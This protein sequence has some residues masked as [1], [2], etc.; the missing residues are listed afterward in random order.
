MNVEHDLLCLGPAGHALQ[1]VTRVADSDWELLRAD[2]AKRRGPASLGDYDL[3]AGILPLDIIV[4]ALERIE[5]LI[6]LDPDR[7]LVAVRL[8]P[9]PDRIDVDADE[10]DE[11]EELLRARVGAPEIRFLRR[12]HGHLREV[13]L[14]LPQVLREDAV[15]DH[16]RVL[17]ADEDARDV[18]ARRGRLHEVLVVTGCPIVLAVEQEEA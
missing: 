10:I 1:I 6:R 13:G 7:L 11:G 12:P 2:R 17:I 9:V 16:W 15:V 5:A 4:G 18:A 3:L 14:H 8:R